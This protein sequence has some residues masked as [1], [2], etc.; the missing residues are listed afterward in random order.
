MSFCVCTVACRLAFCMVC[1]SVLPAG[2]NA[3]IL[4]KTGKKKED[5]P[6]GCN[7]QKSKKANCPIPGRCK[8]EALVYKATIVTTDKTERYIGSTENSFKSRYYG[9]AADMREKEKEGGTTLSTYY[10]KKANEGNA[11]T[12]SWEILRKCSKYKKG[13]R[14]C[15]VCLTEKLEILKTKEKLLNKRTELM[16]KC[17]HRRKHRL[18]MFDET[19][20]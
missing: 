20:P 9:H 15:D 19:P 12:V 18:M 5:D 4:R 14:N 8:E 6:K 7:C 11:P 1:S 16:Y 13:S 2:H 10:W 17:P 3:K